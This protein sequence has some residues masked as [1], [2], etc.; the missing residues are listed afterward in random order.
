[1]RIFVTGGAGFIGRHLVESLISKHHHVTIFDNFSNS[2]KSEISYLLKNEV[3]LISGDITE[4]ESL[5]KSLKEYDF[6]F[7]L[8]AQINVAA[9]ISNPDY[10]NK[11]N[12]LGTKNLLDVCVKNQIK[13][14]IVASS[15]AVFGEPKNLPLTEKSPLLPISPYG[16]SKVSME[17]LVKECSEKYNINCII[18]RFFNIYGKGQSD[19]YAGVIS[20]FLKKIDENNNLIIYGEGSQTR[21]FLS[22]EDLVGALELAMENIDGKRGSCYNIGYGKSVSINELAKLMISLS[23]TILQT[24]HKP[25]KK[26]D[27]NHSVTSIELARKELNFEP[28]TSLQNGIKKLLS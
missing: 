9:S 22:V 25:R 20:K 26:G 8:A 2:S 28:K 10:T 16:K 21:D 14:T 5:E 23:G 17:K 18:L 13:N 24:E 12:V 27:I 6:V 3:Q 15:A 19:E 11:V 1:M 7:H 4:F